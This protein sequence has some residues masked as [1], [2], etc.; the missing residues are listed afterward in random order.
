MAGKNHNENNVSVSG[1][2]LISYNQF[3]FNKVDLRGNH[4]FLM[5]T[6]AKIKLYNEIFD[7][8]FFSET[9]FDDDGI[10]TFFHIVI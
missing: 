2:F 7:I 8:F 10:I 3:I 6:S 1:Q 5:G 4:A 9:L